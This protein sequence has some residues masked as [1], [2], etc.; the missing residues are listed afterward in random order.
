MT[1][2]KKPAVKKGEYLEAVG[3]RKTSVARVRI[4]H[5]PK[6]LV[7]EG[8]DFTPALELITVNEKPV[9]TYFPLK[10]HHRVIVSPFQKSDL[11]GHFK[12]TIHTLGGGVS[13]QAFAVR[14]GIARALLE[15]DAELRKKLKKFGYLTRDPRMVE[16]K[17]YGLK[18]ARR[19]PQWSKR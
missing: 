15:F 11:L 1:T 2:I 13:S 10:N 4:Y 9:T 3:R 14:H 19:A 7:V 12:V 5:M 16:R 8:T 6:P 18:K 17:K